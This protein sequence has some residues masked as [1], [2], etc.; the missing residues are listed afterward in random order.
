MSLQ[1]LF[2]LLAIH[3]LLCPL[4]F[5]FHVGPIHWDRCHTIRNALVGVYAGHVVLL[6]Q[7]SNRQFAF[8]YRKVLANTVARSLQKG[9]VLVRVLYDWGGTPTKRSGTNSSGLSQYCSNW[10]I[11]YGTTYKTPP[12]NGLALPSFVQICRMPGRGARRVQTQYF[13]KDGIQIFTVLQ[14][15]VGRSLIGSVENFGVS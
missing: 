12:P 8:Q 3:H 14:V 13:L 5:E 15:I 4:F 1:R 6:H 7:G 2:V 9:N 10:C 11:T